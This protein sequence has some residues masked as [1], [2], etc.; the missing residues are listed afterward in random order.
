[1]ED[2]QPLADQHQKNP[3][4]RHPAQTRDQTWI[5]AERNSGGVDGSFVMRATDDRA[6]MVRAYKCKRGFDIGDCRAS[7]SGLDAPRDEGV[8]RQRV[9]RKHVDRLRDRWIAGCNFANRRSLLLPAPH[10]A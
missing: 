3:V 1:M 10:S 6:R 2:T 5:T 4:F 9:D 7:G 8:V